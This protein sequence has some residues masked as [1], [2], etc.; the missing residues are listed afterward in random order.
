MTFL[1]LVS[2]TG[3]FILSSWVEVKFIEY[4]SFWRWKQINKMN[5]DQKSQTNTSTVPHDGFL[6][7]TIE[8]CLIVI[9]CYYHWTILYSL[10]N[11]TKL[12]KHYVILKSV[13]DYQIDC[14][15]MRLINISNTY[16]MKQLKFA[17]ILNLSKINVSTSIASCK[18]WW[19]SKWYNR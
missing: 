4:I 14:L 6:P 16:E 5:V 2:N 19:F 13:F 10:K 7:P 8:V 3:I 9:V 11:H 17:A 18:R 15:F 12:Y 1:Q